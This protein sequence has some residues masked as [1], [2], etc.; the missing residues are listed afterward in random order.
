M[1]EIVSGI[2]QS[3]S[4]RGDIP[5]NVLLPKSYAASRRRF[6]VLYLLHGLFGNCNNWI[7]LT[8]LATYTDLHD[9]IVVTPE[10]YDSWYVDSATERRAKFESYFLNDL[11][12]MIDASFRTRTG[13]RSLGIA[14]N[15]MG[16]YGAVKF[17]FKRPDLFCFAASSSGAFHGPLLSENAR[18]AGWEELGPSITKAFGKSGSRTRKGND[19]FRIVSNFGSKGQSAPAVFLDCGKDDSFLEI[20]REFSRTLTK[21]GMRHTYREFAGGHDWIYWDKRCRNFF[22]V[23]NELLR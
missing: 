6:P 3:R 20:N 11:M 14:G 4:L 1:A 22:Q 23:A 7:E 10:G 12:P 16:G 13:R 15:S 21:C 18:D 17:A 2:L 5:Y 9:L 8:K 19:L